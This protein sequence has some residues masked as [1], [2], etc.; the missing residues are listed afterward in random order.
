[1]KYN[2]HEFNENVDI[3]NAFANYCSTSFAPYGD[4]FGNADS[5]YSL[6]NNIAIHVSDFELN[7]VI[8]TLKKIKNKMTTGPDGVLAFLL[9]D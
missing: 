5:E 6:G 1:M 8:E 2:D 4:F 3:L 7:D 9:R